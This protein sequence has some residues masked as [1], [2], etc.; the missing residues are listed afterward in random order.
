MPR[1]SWTQREYDVARELGKKV[2]VFLCKG[3]FD[4]GDCARSPTS[5]RSVSGRT[6]KNSAGQKFDSG[7][8]SE[9]ASRQELRER[10][11]EIPFRPYTPWQLLAG[12][13]ALIVILG[14]VIWGISQLGKK[15]DDARRVPR[16]GT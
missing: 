14:G 6:A 2:Y 8:W 10:V 15:V 11:R 4:F 7:M 1:R 3:G 16:R 12:V 5:C 9:V 13:A